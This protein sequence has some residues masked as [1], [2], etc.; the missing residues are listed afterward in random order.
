MYTF[1][2]R[3]CECRLMRYITD[4]RSPVKSRTTTS[5]ASKL[6]LQDF[7]R[8]ARPVPAH[9]P[10]G[11]MKHSLP[12]HGEL[13]TAR[14]PP[15]GEI[16]CYNNI[17]HCSKS[18]TIQMQRASKSIK[19]QSSYLTKVPNLLLHF[20]SPLFICMYVYLHVLVDTGFVNPHSI[21]M[22]CICLALFFGT[23]SFAD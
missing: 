13:R 5:G 9:T 23:R 2:Q 20:P 6:I 19:G 3:T 8:S 15:G 11:R 10:W 7:P 4:T 18:K 17:T 1:H 14:L 21:F 12:P 16:I 22:L